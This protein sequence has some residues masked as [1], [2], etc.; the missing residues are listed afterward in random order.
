MKF[1]SKFLYLSLGLIL[2]S[3]RASSQELYVFTEPASNMPAKSLGIRASNWLMYD[4]SG[5]TLNY[6]LIP[7]VML[8]V[9][10]NIML[11]LDGFFTNQGGNFHAVGAGTYIKYRLYS[12]DAINRH[13]R[14]AAFGRVSLNNSAI[15]QEEI[16]LT[17]NNTGYA[18]GVIATQL[19]HR[20]AISASVSFNQAYNNGAENKF[21]PGQPDQAIN[22]SIST[23]RLILPKEYL[24]YKQTNFNLMLDL[25]GQHLLKENGNFLD[26]AP[27]IQ[28]IFNSQSRLDIGYKFQLYSDMQRV[29]P[30]GFMIRFEHLLFNVL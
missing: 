18:V 10:K 26:M 1:F 30:N 16:D 23:G 2:I 3:Y 29:A 11:H 22:F 24:S 13:F 8:G 28:F 17:R 14:V 19:L 6:Q 4:K 7:E 12:A 21:P 20:Q 15:F 25:M 5:S 27:A 9:N